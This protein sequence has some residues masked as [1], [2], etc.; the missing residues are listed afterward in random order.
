MQFN[1][2]MKREIEKDSGSGKSKPE[3]YKPLPDKSGAKVNNNVIIPLFAP[4]MWKMFN[5]DEETINKLGL[6]GVPGQTISIPPDLLSFY[7]KIPAHGVNNYKRPDGSIGFTWLMCPVAMERYLV[8]FLGFDNMWEK[9]H[10]PFCDYANEW[11][12][13]H[14]DR[15]EQLGYDKDSRRGLGKD[16]YHAMVGSDPGLKM[17][18]KNAKK[19]ALRDRYVM[20]IFDYDK[21][22]GVRPFDN[23]QTAPQHQIFFSAK[24]VFEKLSNLSE[25][26]HHFYYFE[27]NQVQT[28]VIIRDTTNC[29]GNDLSQTK[30]DAITGKKVDMDPAWV[31]YIQNTQLMV[32]PTQFIAMESVEDMKFYIDKDNE[33]DNKP[34]SGFV[35]SHPSANQPMNA[36]VGQPPMGQMNQPPV[37]QQPPMNQQ[38]Q[39]PQQMT[40]PG[41]P[42]MGQPPQTPPPAQQAQPQGQPPAQDPNSGDRTPPAG[43]PPPG[44]MSW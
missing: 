28:I 18:Y 22:T 3:L 5:P 33:K 21:M 19:Y 31:Q 10:C 13:N 43:S 37:N 29:S 15:F 6:K 35:S 32:D 17:S 40:P 1:M 41:A 44:R 36:G 39:P 30:Y 16:A 14:S 8:D 12:N 27:N 23:G 42:P 7:F 20:P 34:V 2:P 25:N 4:P 24:S 11:W 38:A 9:P 26:D